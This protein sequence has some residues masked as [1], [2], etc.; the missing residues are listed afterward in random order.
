MAVAPPERATM[1]TPTGI[2]HGAAARPR[3]LFVCAE[4]GGE[5]LAIRN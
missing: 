2:S 1:A 4:P 5:Q 3:V